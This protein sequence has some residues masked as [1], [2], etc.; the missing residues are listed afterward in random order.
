MVQ[1]LNDFGNLLE[2]STDEGKTK[3]A[4]TREQFD[5]FFPPEEVTSVTDEVS[6]TVDE[7][8]SLPDTT[9]NLPVEEPVEISLQPPVVTPQPDVEPVTAPVQPLGTP[10]PTVPPEPEVASVTAPVTTVVDEALTPPPPVV[11]GPLPPRVPLPKNPT[12]AQVIESRRLTGESNAAVLERLGQ[13][14]V[15]QL[16][17]EVGIREKFDAEKTA[18]ETEGI[19]R[20]EARAVK[21]LE[22]E[23]RLKKRVDLAVNTK[24]KSFWENAS[25]PQK[26]STALSLIFAGLG[27]AFGSTKERRAN[28][29]QGFKLIDKAV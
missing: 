27:K 16:Q 13:I 18:V 3:F 28:S 29:A 11:T 6:T 19:A 8:L 10:V 17:A 7:T 5:K 24:I 26:I 2:V 23:E 25:T 22:V 21:R 9:Q 4:I 1:I 14:K 15:R 12:L 20:R